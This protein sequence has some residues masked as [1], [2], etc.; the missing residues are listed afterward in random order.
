MK[1]PKFTESQIVKAIK[2]AENGRSILKTMC[3]LYLIISSTLLLPSCLGTD[4]DE[5]KA[6]LE[7]RQ[8]TKARIEKENQNAVLALVEQNDAWMGW[9]TTYPI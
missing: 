6:K 8:E 5:L 7:Q 4:E 3:L 9:D 1:K 2:E